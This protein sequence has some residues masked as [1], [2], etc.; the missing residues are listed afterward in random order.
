MLAITQPWLSGLQKS[1]CLFRRVGAP[2]L[3]PF[4]NENMRFLENLKRE[5]GAG[6]R[7]HFFGFLRAPDHL[8]QRKIRLRINEA[9]EA[10]LQ[11]RPAAGTRAH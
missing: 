4:V 6:V 8:D 5:K 2:L 1:A 3:G 11:D 9:V 7:Q 10:L